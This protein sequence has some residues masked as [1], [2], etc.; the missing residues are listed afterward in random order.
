M[1][2]GH[3]NLSLAELENLRSVKF[4]VSKALCLL[5]VSIKQTFH[6]SATAFTSAGRE[7]IP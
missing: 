3:T 6:V 1:N 2:C 7:E 4:V 5:C